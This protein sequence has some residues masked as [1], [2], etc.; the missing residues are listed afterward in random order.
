MYIQGTCFKDYVIRRYLGPIM[1][2]QGLQKYVYSGYMYSRLYNFK[3][4]WA[5]YVNPGSTAVCVSRVHVLKH[6]I[7]LSGAYNVY[8]WSTELCVS[9]I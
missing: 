1:C 2:I 6:I 3:T 7:G 8:S 5:H 9:N 4:S